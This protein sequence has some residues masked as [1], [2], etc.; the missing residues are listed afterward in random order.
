MGEEG[1]GVYRQIIKPRSSGGNRHRAKTGGYGS[2]TRTA[3]QDLKDVAG[4]GL[5]SSTTHAS[6]ESR[7]SRDSNKKA[8]KVL[9]ACTSH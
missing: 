3:R 4:S 6:V 1:E 9:P 8:T 2:R 5:K 7:D